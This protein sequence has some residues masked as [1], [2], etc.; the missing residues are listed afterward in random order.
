M[1]PWVTGPCTQIISA[2]GGGREEGREALKFNPQ[3]FFSFFF[4]PN[5]SYFSFKEKAL[6]SGAAHTDT[7]PRLAAGGCSFPPPL[8]L[9]P[10]GGQDAPAG[11]A[12]PLREA[13]GQAAG[14]GF[15]CP[16]ETQD[17]LPCRR[18][19][20]ETRALLLQGSRP[21]CRCPRSCCL[22]RASRGGEGPRDSTTSNP[23]H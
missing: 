11:T 13:A 9:L 12:E 17:T 3:R 22:V 18:P 15:G 8:T 6:P 19:P 2:F 20:E 23:W 10:G 4:G 5:K 21:G 14:T 7:A 1:P 16:C